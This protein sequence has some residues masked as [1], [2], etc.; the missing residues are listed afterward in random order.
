MLNLPPFPHQP[1]Q[2]DL[3]L[4]ISQI[5]ELFPDLSPSFLRLC[6]LHPTYTASGA[7][8][9]IA[10]LLEGTLPAE[11]EKARDGVEVDN[12]AILQE[13]EQRNALPEPTRVEPT[14]TTT[15]RSN[16]FAEPLN[17]GKVRRGKE[18]YVTSSCFF[19]SST[20]HL[21]AT[22]LPRYLN[23]ATDLLS[24]R[25]FMT[26]SIKASI[27]AR[28]EHESSDEEGEEGQ[29]EAFVEDYDAPEAGRFG[30]RD[31]G[32]GEEGEEMIRERKAADSS[33]S[34]TPVGSGRSTPVVSS[35]FV[36]FSLS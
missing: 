15:R 31:A 23:S 16:I 13:Q 10:A 18:R 2:P 33:R 5:T 28:A 34:G 26:E 22:A 3:T 27:I 20:L 7:E 1:A 12:K 19:F 14:T 29:T 6:L 11:L 17:A 21:T 24:D 4:P 8:G 25:S 36:G 30:V 9:V 32:E 35:C